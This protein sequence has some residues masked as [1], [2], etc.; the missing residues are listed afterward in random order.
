M[1]FSPKW[2]AKSPN[3]KRKRAR[4]NRPYHR[5]EELGSLYSS[6]ETRDARS[7]ARIFERD[8]AEEEGHERRSERAS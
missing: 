8:Y 7:G 4:D 6:S 5:T 2:T 1:K 3:I